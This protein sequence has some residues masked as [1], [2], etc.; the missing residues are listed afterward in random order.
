MKQIQVDPSAAPGADSALLATRRGRETLRRPSGSRGILAY[1]DLN[2]AV[3]ESI[4]LLGW[5]GVALECV[6][7][8]DALVVP[9]VRWNE[10]G[11][12][13]RR[14]KKLG[15]IVDRAWWLASAD[16]SYGDAPAA[17]LFIQGF[18]VLGALDRARAALG[19]L[20]TTAP[21]A[22]LI[23]STPEPGAIELLRCDYYG[24]SVVA[25]VA[26]TVELIVNGGP[27]SPPDGEV[28]FQRK[29]REEQLFEIALRC[30]QVPLSL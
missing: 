6:W 12:R 2:K 24:Y 9:V 15:P 20:R 8:A 27:W 7:L 14:T 18:L 13:A 28:H 1:R 30:G 16:A 22:A 25:T 21:V 10:H 26:A 5:D 17:P 19:R 23:E 4:G 11:W 3:G 29:L